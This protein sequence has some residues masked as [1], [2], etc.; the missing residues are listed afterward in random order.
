MGRPSKITWE[1]R[2]IVWLW[3]AV[4][5]FWAFSQREYLTWEQQTD[6]PVENAGHRGAFSGMHNGHLIVAGGYSARKRDTSGNFIASDRIVVGERGENGKIIWHSDPF[7]KLPYRVSD[8]ISVTVPQG[9]LCVAGKREENILRGTMLLQWDEQANQVRPHRLPPLPVGTSFSTGAAIGDVAYVFVSPHDSDTNQLYRL[10]LSDPDADL[11]WE[12][13]AD[14]PGIPRYDAVAAVQEDGTGKHLFIF[15]GMTLSHHPL[16]FLNETWKYNVDTDHWEQK[17]PISLDS[18]SYL[19]V[20]IPATEAGVHHILLFGPWGGDTVNVVLAYH[21][22]T[23]T[24][25]MVDTFPGLLPR[26]TQAHWWDGKIVIPCGS[27][28]H[29][30]QTAAVWEFTPNPA[31]EG[32]Y[33]LDYIVIALY[34]VIL[35]W[36][37]AHFMRRGRTTAD[38]FTAGKRIPW[39]AAGISIF[40]TSLSAITYMAVPAKAFSS[41][42]TFMLLN[43]AQLLTAP[44][45]IWLVLPF[46]RRLD[47]TTAYEYLERRFNVLVRVLG[48]LAFL[49]FQFGR[50]GIVLFLPAIAL[51]VVTGVSIETCIIVMAILSI[52]YTVL[53]GIEAVIWTDVKQVV[54]LTLGAVVSLILLINGVDGGWDTM[55]E[56]ALA[57]DKLRL[58]NLHFNFNEPTLWVMLGGGVATNLINQ[59]SDQT[60]VQRYLTTKTEKAAARSL[61]TPAALVIPVSILFFGLGTALYG[62]YKTH[63]AELNPVL[64]NG[65]AIFPWYI[66]TQL[67]AGMSGLLIAGIFA[68]SM[69]SLDSSLNSAATV[70]TVDFYKRFVPRGIDKHYLA[71]A[72]IATIVIGLAGMGFA[73]LLA[74]AEIKSLWDEF[75]KVLGLFAGGLAGLFLLGMSSRFATTGGALVGF[76]ASALVQYWVSSTGAVHFLLYTFTGLASCYVIGWAAS[77]AFPRKRDLHGLTIGTIRQM[78]KEERGEL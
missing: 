53:G 68:A 5:P 43:V 36:M 55:Q 75:A 60:F 50:V 63:P 39:W 24:W 57:D 54:V 67:P 14:F 11:K 25:A 76:G 15:G 20:G 37:G 3:L 70:I 9:V 34:L 40:G 48:G 26:Y 23:D 27:P 21:T 69:S 62:F 2:I 58:V 18:N 65:D 16:R 64:E 8:G 71:V 77:W 59:S 46:Y 49:L 74:G 45:V 19:P 72:R 33:W 61:L 38:Y 41:D 51:S 29:E 56:I 44:L 1:R 52:V 6:I 22:L 42:W 66:I 78:G 13:L 17:A 31:P 4:A 32:L 7:W 12:P 35:V 47:V 10:D 30:N 28:D 73:L